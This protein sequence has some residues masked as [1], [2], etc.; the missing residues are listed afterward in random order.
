MV[1][2]IE[3]PRSAI[4]MLGEVGHGNYGYVYKAALSAGAAGTATGRSKSLT[5]VA[6][7]LPVHLKS[8]GE[9][10]R[11]SQEA[12]IEQNSA[13][14]LEAFVLHGL[15]HPR[16]VSIVALVARTQPV[17]MCLEYMENGDLRT[18]LRG[19]H[20]FIRRAT[21]RLVPPLIHWLL[22]PAGEFLYAHTVAT[23]L[24][25]I[26][27][28]CAH[29]WIDCERACAGQ[30]PAGTAGTKGGNHPRGDGA[31]VRQSLQRHGVFGAQ[32]H[33]SPYVPCTHA[34]FQPAARDL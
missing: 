17:M 23:L 9:A 14:L 3:V 33:H 30:V 32:P 34:R 19:Y 11:P 16:I 4:K 31:D 20:P 28:L 1:A 7:K 12:S 6:V 18:Y 10:A 24:L 27:V 22:Q 21:K 8:L 15:K 2:K 26:L 29:C 13:L 5:I 25:I